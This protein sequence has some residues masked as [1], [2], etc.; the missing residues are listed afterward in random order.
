MLREAK[1]EDAQAI[2]NLICFYSENGKMLFR[3]LEEI[4][5][6]IADFLVWEQHGQVVGIC[7]LKFGWDKLVEI[8]SLGV[9]PRYHRQGIATKMVQGSIERALL[10]D[11]CDT[12]FVLTYALPLFTKLGFQIVDKMELPQKVWN[13]CQACLH[14]DNCDETAM[15]LSLIPLKKQAIDEIQYS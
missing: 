11:D 6:N 15:S 14:K 7:S 1:I 8:R 4:E 10:R 13:D 2:Q 5:K 12:A 9:D 3:T